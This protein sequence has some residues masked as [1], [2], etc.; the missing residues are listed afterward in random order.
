MGGVNNPLRAVE[1]WGKGGRELLAV[2]LRGKKHRARAAA[3]NLHYEGA[4]IVAIAG[5]A[6]GIDGKGARTRGEAG[7]GSGEF[8]R[9]GKNRRDALERPAA[10]FWHI[11]GRAR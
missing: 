8:L 2:A 6:L 3:A 4:I 9:G 11:S 10:Q 7:C 5:G 1:H